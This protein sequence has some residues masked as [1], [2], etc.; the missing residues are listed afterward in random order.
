M[1]RHDRLNYHPLVNSQ[2]TTI[3]RDDLIRFIEAGGHA[4]EIVD[5]DGLS[6]RPGEE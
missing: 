3:A 2:T 1:L 6:G 5:I 4:C